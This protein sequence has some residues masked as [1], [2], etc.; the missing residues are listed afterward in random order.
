MNTKSINNIFIETTGALQGGLAWAEFKP[1]R[2]SKRVNLIITPD[3]N[4]KA[5]HLAFYDRPCEKPFSTRCL[6]GFF[7]SDIPL[8]ANVRANVGLKTDDERLFG[9][10]FIDEIEEGK[11]LEGREI[12]SGFAIHILNE[13]GTKGALGSPHPKDQNLRLCAD[14]KYRKIKYSRKH[15]EWYYT[16]SNHEVLQKKKETSAGFPSGVDGDREF[17]RFFSLLT[18]APHN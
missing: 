15:N 1:V 18:S 5:I 14:G 4:K 10:W 9:V 3:G 8:Y 2:N 12:D 16:K 13:E 6:Y 11:N 17:E 7:D